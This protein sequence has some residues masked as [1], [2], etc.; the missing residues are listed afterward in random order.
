MLLSIVD[1]DLNEDFNSDEALRFLKVGLLCTQDAPKLRPAMSS[2]VRMLMGKKHIDTEF[3]TKPRFIFDSKDVKL[4]GE[5]TQMGSTNTHSSGC[6][7]TDD[8]A[9]SGFTHPSITFTAICDR[10]D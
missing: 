10:E 7:R 8:S 1:T 6:S 2:V 3:I 9:L 5:N 4:K